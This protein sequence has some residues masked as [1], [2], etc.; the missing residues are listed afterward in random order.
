MVGVDLEE[1]SLQAGWSARRRTEPRVPRR[2]RR[3]PPVRRRRVR[4]G[5]RDRGPRA[6][7]GP[8]A[9]ARRDARAARARHLLV[10]VPR[11]P[12]WRA[13]NMLRGAYWRALGNTPGHLNHWSKR[14]AS[15]VC[16]RDTARSWRCARRCP[17]RSSWCALAASR[18]PT[19][20]SNASGPAPS[21]ARS[22]R[23]YVSGAR[24]LSVGIAATG[25]LTFAY[26]SI[27]SHVL[28]EARGEPHR[29]PVV[30]DVRGD[31]GDLPAD[32]TAALA[33]DRRAPRARRAPAPARRAACDPGAASR[34]VFLVA[35]LALREPLLGSSV[36]DEARSA[37]LGARGRHARL[38][39]ELLRARLAG[40]ARTLRA[41]RRRWC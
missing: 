31:L 30:R 39:G 34:C 37:L 18:W 16:W 35:A 19:S 22:T 6:P 2:P 7:R 12:L 33:L 8:A 1:D 27:A 9:R 26:F 23:S 28:G 32:R 24:M 10:S 3:A 13:L 11:E 29:R 4:A 38:R 14:R 21:A 15:C 17:G 5:E 41:L 40:R 36:F 20:D 25:L